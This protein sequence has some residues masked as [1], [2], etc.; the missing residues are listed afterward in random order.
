MAA[1]WFLRR[2]ALCGYVITQQKH[3]RDGSGVN[4]LIQVV[5]NDV[6]LAVGFNISNVVND[7]DERGLLGVTAD[8]DFSNNGYVYLYYTRNDST[9]RNRVSRFTMNG[10][11]LDPASETLIFELDPL[12]TAGNHNGGGL[13]FG[14]DGKLYI[15]VGENTISSN[16]QST[17]SL[18]GKIH[19]INKDGTIPTD[20]PMYNTLTG[21]FCITIDEST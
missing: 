6:M 14:A 12:S 10:D 1:Y 18:L 13:S 20:N 11:L 16:A 2:K 7:F 9:L 4:R 8:P 5:K 15:S 17:S 21:K 3:K 19:R